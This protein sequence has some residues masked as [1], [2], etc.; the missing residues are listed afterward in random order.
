[1]ETGYKIIAIVAIWIGFGIFSSLNAQVQSDFLLLGSDGKQFVSETYNLDSGLPVNFVNQLLQTPDGYLWM[2][3]YSGLI[4][5]DGVKFRVFDVGNSPGLP[6]NR[7]ERIQPGQG[8]SLWLTTEQKQLLFF[9]NGVFTVADDEIVDVNSVYLDGDSLTWVSSK[10]YLYQFIDGQL[11]E[12]KPEGFPHLHVGAIGRSKDGAILIGNHPGKIIKSKFPYTDFQILETGEDRSAGIILEDGQGKIW[13]ATNNLS[14]HKG[15][16]SKNWSHEKEMYQFWTGIPPFFYNIQE[17]ENGRV[18][19][20]SETGIFLL[21]ENSIT[22]VDVHGKSGTPSLA[23]RTGRSM[24]KCADGTVWIV[25][26]GKVFK[27]GQ[28]QFSPTGGANT[29]YCDQESNIWLTNVRGGISRFRTTF[30]KNH[31]NPFTTNNYYSVYEDRYGRVWFGEWQ[32][33]IN[34]LDQ[35]DKIQRFNTPMPWGSSGSIFETA[36]GSFFIGHMRCPPENRTYDG[37]CLAFEPLDGI[38]ERIFAGLE[39]K[40]GDI[41]FGSADGLYLFKDNVATLQL[42]SESGVEKP[43]RFLIESK[44]GSIWMAT[45]GNGIRKYDPNTMKST[46]Y[47]VNEGLSS[48]NVRALM[49]DMNGNIWVVTEDKGL[50]RL[51]VDSGQIQK[52]SSS[53]GLYDDGL[54]TIQLDDFGKVWMSTNRG[55]FW[56]EFR[57]LDLFMDGELSKVRSVFYSE[58]DGMRN[59]E[60]NGGFQNSSLKTADGRLWFCTQEGVV[61]IQPK[62]LEIRQTPTMPIIENLILTGQDRLIIQRLVT[63]NPHENNFTIQFSSPVFTNPGLLRYRYKLEGFDR[64]WIENGAR[65]EAVYTNIP[66]GNYQFLVASFFEGGNTSSIPAVIDI[67]KLPLFHETWWFRLLGG[68]AIGLF[69]LGGYKFRTGQLKRR[70]RELEILIEKRT[71]ELKKEKSLTDSQKEKLVQIAKEK[72]RFFANISHEFRTP[73]TLIL[74]PLKELQQGEIRNYLP[75]ETADQVKIA[76]RNTHRMIRLVSQL[77]D[78]AKLDAG[79]FHLSLKVNSINEYLREITSFFWGIAERKS[80]VYQVIIPDKP[81]YVAFDPDHFDKIIT[82]LISNAFKFTSVHGKIEITVITKESEVTIT[83]S[84]DGLGIAPE[85]LPHLFDHFYQIEKS[86]LQPGTGIGLSLAKELTVLHGGNISVESSRGNGSKFT[87]VFPLA[88]TQNKLETEEQIKSTYKIE[89]FVETDFFQ[90]IRS[91]SVPESL[92]ESE[93]RTTIL[94]VD[95]NRDIRNYLSMYLNKKYK[96]LEAVSGNQ[97]MDIIHLQLPDI[98]VSDIMMADGDGITLLRNIRNN[99]NWAFLPVVLLTAKAEVADRLEALEIGAD[100]YITKPFDM[101]ELQ[102]RIGNLLSKRKRLLHYFE[103]AYVNKANLFFGDV[104]SDSMDKVFLEKLHLVLLDGLADE[105]FT[106]ETMSEK[107]NRSRSNLYRKTLS[108]TGESPSNLLKRLRLERSADLLVA[109]AGTISEVAYSCGFNS[110]SH[111]SKIFREKY[112]R[113]PSEFT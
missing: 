36:D 102:A 106:V 109:N 24:C 97:A 51:Q 94:I 113:S 69:F 3:T 27:N 53:D 73:L 93:D 26:E 92:E 67:V 47:T 30:L 18:W 90:E 19:A 56:I 48:N 82:N 43:V 60:G 103:D 1:M 66:G 12:F 61:E 70:Q 37:D 111:F 59:R 75:H 29:I 21:E 41:Y 64:E 84:D 83:V 31:H 86:E 57:E 101:V 16:E 8:N 52:I 13:T 95:D 110:V 5:F 99:P 9:E 7:I 35:Q 4:R 33:T 45:N 81:I 2:A 89:S 32:N 88:A 105:N 34:Y 77:L 85:H 50:N 38:G 6:T 100:D 62:E 107:L 20:I 15:N 54:H 49:E 23:V 104:T 25:F 74:G 71:E 72:N 108:L 11:K 79:E 10:G 65:N 76:L 17:D 91:V 80:I 112:G 22:S 87:L 39:S 44:D 42:T 28:Y 78:I 40:N 98:I 96:I 14:W 68:G 46:V 55:I 63:L 58:K